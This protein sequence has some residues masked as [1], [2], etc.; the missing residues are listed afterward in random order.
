MLACERVARLMLP[1]RAENY[2]LRSGNVSQRSAISLVRRRVR[3]TQWHDRHKK[4]HG[5]REKM[6]RF[7]R[8]AM[9]AGS[10][11]ADTLLPGED[12]SDRQRGLE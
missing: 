7:I 12:L 9:E 10:L 2:V 11:H 5:Q 4:L 3:A 8:K 1:L 6:L